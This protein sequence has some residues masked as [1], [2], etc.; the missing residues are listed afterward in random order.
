MGVPMVVRQRLRVEGRGRGRRIIDA[1]V[2]GR[3]VSSPVFEL[4]AMLLSINLIMCCRL[5]HPFSRLRSPSKS[6]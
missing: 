2:H 3:E 5:A 4:F 6:S 1:G